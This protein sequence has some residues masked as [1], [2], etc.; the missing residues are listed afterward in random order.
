MIKL[1]LLII[2][3]AVP[4]LILVSITHKG[5][6]KFLQDRADRKER[7]RIRQEAHD[8]SKELLQYLLADPE[9]ARLIRD[10]LIRELGPGTRTEEEIHDHYTSNEVRNTFRAY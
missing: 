7:A 5:V 9:T 2:A 3:I 8:K 4:I 1:A 6:L 10:N